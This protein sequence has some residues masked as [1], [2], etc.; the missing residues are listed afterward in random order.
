MG[1]N[2]TLHGTF[3]LKLL[4]FFFYLRPPNF[5]FLAPS[6][7]HSLPPACTLL[8]P[9][10]F[11]IFGLPER[12]PGGL[13]LGWPRPLGLLVLWRPRARAAPLSSPAP[14]PLTR[15]LR[16]RG[17]GDTPDPSQPF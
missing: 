11:L 4:S 10:L 14:P 9:L 15:L 3:P 5:C 1:C 7:A 17:P 6:L 13:T 2:F 12:S 8:F 16:T